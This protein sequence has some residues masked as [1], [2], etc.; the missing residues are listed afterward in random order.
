MVKHDTTHNALQDT[1]SRFKC[2]ADE[3][4]IDD[5][6]VRFKAIWK[7]IEFIVDFLQGQEY[8]INCKGNN[9]EEG[10]GNAQK[11]R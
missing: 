10:K 1:Q 11:V 7:Y 8:T 6:F 5:Y 9:R 2:F 3:F 4:T